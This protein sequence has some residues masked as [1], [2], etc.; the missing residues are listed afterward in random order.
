MTGT[1]LHGKKTKYKILEK[2]GNGGFGIVY[3]A[4][5]LT[6]NNNVAI[7]VFRNE[8]DP[9]DTDALIDWERE[10]KQALTFKHKNIIGSI[11][12]AET[13]LDSGLKIYFLVM[14]YAENGNLS[15]I[16]EAQS[17]R[18]S[19]TSEKEITTLLQQMLDGLKEV[20]TTT[21]HRDLKPENMLFVGDI[22]K[23]SDFGLAKYVEQ[24]TR[25]RTFKGAGTLFY[26]A[27]ETWNLQRT[28]P[29]TDIYSLGV[30]L[31]LLCTNELPWLFRYVI[32]ASTHAGFRM[33]PHEST[34]H[35]R[36]YERAHSIVGKEGR[37]HWRCVMPAR[38][39][40]PS[41]P[42]DRWCQTPR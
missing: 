32:S 36:G 28:S 3:K 21:I 38:P 25:T 6:T 11:G 13:T 8:L 1:I 37:V 29:A 33:I 27:P 42:G 9:G 22:L 20:H 40:V 19:F 18:N 17:S 39:A 2:I 34:S 23:I 10:A 26:M 24:S 5:D 12:F 4:Q 14:E 41:P 30:I 7:K 35:S 31:Y 16:V 15:A